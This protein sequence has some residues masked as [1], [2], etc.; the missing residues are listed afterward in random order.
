QRH[1]IIKHVSILDEPMR[2]RPND[3]QVLR[4]IAVE[5]K[6]KD[7]PEFEQTSDREHGGSNPQLGPGN[8]AKPLPK[9]A[10]RKPSLAISCSWRALVMH[11]CSVSLWRSA[12]S[13]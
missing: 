7:V 1:V 11:V 6:Q 8:Y 2:P 9:P 5:P 10:G 4:L 13:G 3:V 12:G